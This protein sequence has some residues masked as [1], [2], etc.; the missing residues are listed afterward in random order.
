MIA[1]TAW[2]KLRDCRIPYGELL[3]KVK[4]QMWRGNHKKLS[5]VIVYLQFVWYHPQAN[6]INAWFYWLHGV[7]RGIS[8]R[9]TIQLSIIGVQIHLLL[10]M[11][12][13]WEHPYSLLKSQLWK[14]WTKIKVPILFITTKRFSEHHTSIPVVIIVTC[15]SQH[16]MTLLVPCNNTIIWILYKED[17]PTLYSQITGN[18]QWHITRSHTPISHYCFN[19]LTI[20]QHFINS[21][22][23]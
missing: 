10:F 21:Y 3:I 5:F 16:H 20:S 22:K 17:S 23:M 1:T 8:L 14:K 7:H 12:K 18:T 6:V 2:W 4:R 15:T 9:G 13:K 19:G 11:C